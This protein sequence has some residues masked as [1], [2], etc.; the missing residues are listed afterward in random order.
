MTELPQSG[1]Y[2]EEIN[3]RLYQSLEEARFLLLYPDQHFF[4]KLTL[5]LTG[6]CRYLTRFKKIIRDQRV[7]EDNQVDPSA[8]ETCLASV[9]PVEDASVTAEEEGDE[10]CIVACAN[11]SSLMQSVDT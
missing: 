4:L 2:Y 5:M 10:V 7:Y 6:I 8:L 11:A 3:Y 9:A 1:R